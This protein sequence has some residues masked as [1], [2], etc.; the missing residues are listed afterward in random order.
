MDAP[1]IKEIKV[2]KRYTRKDGTVAVKEYTQRYV[3]KNNARKNLIKE[4]TA[5]L[6]NTTD[7]TLIRINELLK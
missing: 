4:I 2:V 3:V 6:D 7:E 5:K 1:I